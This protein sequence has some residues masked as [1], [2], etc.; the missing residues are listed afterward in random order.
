[1]FLAVS[2]QDSG[3][4][5]GQAYHVQYVDSE[6]LYSTGGQQQTQMAYP[7][8][9]VGDYSSSGQ[10]YYTTTTTT[11]QQPSSSN[12]YNN[13]GASS[14]VTTTTNSHAPQTAITTSNSSQQYLVDESI[15]STGSS[16]PQPSR[17]SPQTIAAV[18]SGRL[19]VWP[20]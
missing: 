2:S 19:N 6:T 20:V 3:H 12:G 7:V 1:M 15:L 18:I 5:G 4:H 17:D 13:S 9:A 8:Y 16:T 11:P 10:Q 14:T